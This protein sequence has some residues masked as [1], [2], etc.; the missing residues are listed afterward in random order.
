LE[1]EDDEMVAA[2]EWAVSKRDDAW[3]LD[4]EIAA[5]HVELTHAWMLGYFKAH[6]A[7]NVGKPIRIERPWDKKAQRESMVGFRSFAAMIGSDR[8]K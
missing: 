3:T 6:G 7:T 8:G 5:T 2:L 1:E 4:R